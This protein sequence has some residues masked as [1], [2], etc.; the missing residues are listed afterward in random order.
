MIK[1]IKKNKVYGYHWLLES[2]S[3]CGLFYDVGLPSDCRLLDIRMDVELERISKEV[4][5]GG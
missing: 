5:G 1:S 3:F 2:F 4:W